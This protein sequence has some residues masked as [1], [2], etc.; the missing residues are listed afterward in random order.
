MAYQYPYDE[1]LR[2]TPLNPEMIRQRVQTDARRHRLNGLLLG[3]PITIFSSGFFAIFGMTYQWTAGTPALIFGIILALLVGSCAVVGIGLIVNTI[4][5]YRR[6]SRGEIT[7][8]IDKVNYIEHDRPRY[9]YSKRHS[10]TVYEDF[11]HFA[12]GRVFKDAEQ[13]YRHM[14]I[15]DEEFVTVAYT[16]NR[17]T[18]LFIYRLVDYNW[19]K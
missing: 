17:E 8:E 11:L 18:I 1:E 6:A 4:R 9:V 7:I 2:K 19:Q 14:A 15:D 10:H 13:K 5:N 3:L 12:S 16:A